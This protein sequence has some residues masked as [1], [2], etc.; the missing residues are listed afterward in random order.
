MIFQFDLGNSAVKWRALEHGKPMAKGA[1]SHIDDFPSELTAKLSPSDEFQVA[2]VANVH[3]T[4]RLLEEL[5]HRGASD[6]VL[7]V[8]QSE[9][10][11]LV[12]AYS[13]PSSM[14]VDR[15]LA[16]LAAWHG[17]H[18]SFVLVDAGS[19]VTVDVVQE[20]GRHQG[21]FILPGRHLMLDSLQRGTSRVVFRLEEDPDPRL[22]ID[23]QSCVSRGVSWLSQGLAKQVETTA[24]AHGIE[25]IWVT[26]G[27]ARH[28]LN[29]GLQAQHAPDLVMEGLSLYCSSLREVNG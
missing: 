17:S 18:Q 29:A 4:E 10:L 8:S 6:V 14:G 22:G 25:A 23:T 7:A 19:A 21:G 5:A 11:G 9:Q 13:D 20:S 12:N 27:D 15:W 2:S 24:V 3:A 1:F 28:F 16:M 26:G